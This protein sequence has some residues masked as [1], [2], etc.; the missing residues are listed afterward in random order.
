MARTRTMYIFVLFFGLL[1]VMSFSAPV[2]Y[3]ILYMVLL[4]PVVAL[5]AAVLS[6]VFLFTSNRT[7]Q[8]HIFRGEPLDLQVRVRNRGPFSYPHFTFALYDEY[9]TYRGEDTPSEFITPFETMNY[10]YELM[11]P[12]RGVY[13]IGIKKYTVVDFL[14]LFRMSFNIRRHDT[15]MV[16]PKVNPD[17]VLPL[18]SRRLNDGYAGPEMD[19]HDLT[20]VTDIRR[21]NPS[22]DYKRIHWKLTAKR[23]DFIVKEFKT[24]GQD[25]TLV[26]LCR[27]AV[28]ARGRTRL[29]FED[30][31]ATMVISALDV[32]LRNARTG[33]L[34]FSGL[35][36]AEIDVAAPVDMERAYAALAALA[37][38]GTAT[39]GN[40]L[41][42]M[43]ID[44][45]Y[46]SDLIIFSP[47][48]SADSALTLKMLCASGHDVLLY[49]VYP[50]GT[51]PSPQDYEVIDSLTSSGIKVEV[52]R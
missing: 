31:M 38:D 22:D 28:A 14:G 41:K 17:F 34:V 6:P 2:T 52:G 20:D 16:Y 11:F 46:F 3:L 15:V 9:V 23:G 51:S 8:V 4:L 29:A 30:S 21:H 19:S 32:L 50:M 27:D 1:A 48:I 40:E 7:R 10:R 49:I 25:R 24:P 12:Y 36:G 47:M 37:F 42:A 18:A 33:R 43:L 39:L 5:L 44:R 35:R 45:P 26:L 13:D